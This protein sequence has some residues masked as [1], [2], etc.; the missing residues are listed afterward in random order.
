MSYPYGML[1]AM[2]RGFRGG[3]R[4]ARA[5]ARLIERDG[6]RC[7][8]CGFTFT[9]DGIRACTIDHVVPRSQGGTNAVE[10]LRL[11]CW[12]CNAWRNRLPSGEFERSTLL[13]Q[14]RR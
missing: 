14:R 12:Y 7:W 9:D 13:T 10:N 2:P 11:A 8:Y 6:D 4:R 3:E 5:V 1:C